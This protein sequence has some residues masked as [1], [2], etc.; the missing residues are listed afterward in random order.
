VRTLVHLS[1]LHF[2]RIDMAVI[3]PL[4]ATVTQLQ[5]DVVAVSGDLTQ[6]ARPQQ[7]K[8]ARAF[9]DALPTPQIIVPG[10]HDVPLYNLFGRFV[11]RLS[12]Y[13]HYITPDLAPFYADAEIAILGLNTARSLTF[14]GGRINIK[15]MARIRARLGDITSDVVKMLV[16]HHPFE[17]PAE[18]QDR[19]VVRRARLAM[20]MLAACGVDL[21]LSGHLH[22]TYLGH[23]AARYQLGDY[24]ALVIQAG[25]A[26]STRGR[27][28]ANAF[29]VIRI[30]RPQL[31]V[32]SMLWQ[33]ARS[34]FT[35]AS[36]QS[37]RYTPHGWV[38]CSNAPVIDLSPVQKGPAGQDLPGTA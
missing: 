4:I 6:R 24:S 35:P 29:N 11:Q 19:D 14:K 20:K 15:Q 30:A 16:T 7:F 36:T 21:L 34:A 9:L 38:P 5:P 27:G 25:T 28:E 3:D 33:P 2:G 31:T 1:D 8:A 32:E 23:T 18:Y 26:T 10:N 12:T 17:V 22:R 37:F 13:Q